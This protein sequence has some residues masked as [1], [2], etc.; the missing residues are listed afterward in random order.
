VKSEFPNEDLLILDGGSCDVG[1][2]S[3]VLLIKHENE[4]YTL[5]ILRAGLV[6]QKEIERS[7]RNQKFD[8][9]FQETVSKKESPGH[10]KHHYMPEIPLVLVKKKSLSETQIL[11]QTRNSLSKLPDQIEGIQIRKPKSIEKAGELQ[12]P[13]EAALASRLLYS[14]LRKLGE[15]KKFDMIYFRQ[16]AFHES[17]DWAALRDRLS[18]AASLIL[19][20]N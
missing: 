1:L 11:N 14:E 16:N 9:T 8:Y 18:K 6:T 4:K 13:S 20:G 2:E 3:T 10:L 5:S 17:E 12:L 7:L 19:D 15:S